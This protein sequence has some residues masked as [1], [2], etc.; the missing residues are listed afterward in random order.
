[1]S[2]LTTH[3][4]YDDAAETWQSLRDAYAGSGKI[5]PAIDTSPSGRAPGVKLAGSKYL[6]RPTG[7]K[8]DAQYQQYVA[9]AIWYG[10]TERAVHGLTGAIFR[11][12]PQQTAPEAL[13]PQLED[14]TQTGVPW[15]TFA[16]QAVRETLLMGR[17]GVL[18]DFPHGKPRPD[19]TFE[20][21]PPTSRPYWI[22][23]QAEEIVNWRTT[24]RQGD[25]V[26]SLVVLKECIEEPQGVFPS[27]DFFVVKQRTQ[28]RVLRLNEQGFYEIS[29]W[30][31]L[32]AG[33]TDRQPT[34][35]LARPPWM[36]ARYRQPLDFIPFIF[37]APFSLE[38]TIEKSL[39][40]ALVEVNYQY[41]R[42]SADYEQALHLT[43]SP[44]LYICA[45]Q[46]DPQTEIFLGGNT[47][48]VVPDS[49]ATVGLIEFH[50]Q[51]L[52]SHEHAM[53]NDIKNMAAL[54]ARLLESQPL[55]QETLGAVLNRT[56]GTESPIQSL[57]T[58][59]SHGLTQALQ[60][61]CWWAGLTENVD[62]TAITLTLNGDL[63]AMPLDP[64]ML[65]AL[66]QMLL[67]NT[68]SYETYFYNLERGEIARPMI[69]VEEEQALL[70][71]QALQRPLAPV[72]TNGTR[73]GAVAA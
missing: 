61:H 54:G 69:P 71:T 65:T 35:V 62:D 30:V 5:K 37:M 33:P 4:A 34:M 7:M 41:Y 59:V 55:V 72:A 18:V 52:Q 45:S 48:I 32:D 29:L 67:N 64:Q 23:Y 42:H 40:E 22:A 27:P 10:A 53:E 24:Q 14:V 46:L 50:G 17:F 20:D 60:V 39:L 47:A 21:P 51:G 49:T 28:Y 36:P 9:R 1:M 6:P 73:N 8:S 11:R 43:A 57:V 31:E 25:T 70:E 19:G 3:P 58:T 63:L 38:P 12:E 68:I 56:Q 13:V 16:E 66:M 44:S 26:L 15:R 2:V